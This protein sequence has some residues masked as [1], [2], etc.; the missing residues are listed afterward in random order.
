[1]VVVGCVSVGA[2]GAVS[3]LGA[4][5]GLSRVVL[6][7]LGAGR[8]CSTVVDDRVGRGLGVACAGGITGSV[9]A[10]VPGCPGAGGDVEEICG[11]VKFE[12]V[13][14]FVP[15]I[16]SGA[17]GG[18]PGALIVELTPLVWPSWTT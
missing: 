17:G 1:M 7:S 13:S 5:G 18:S 11:R 14:A 16:P 15:V 4:G 8:V 6:V 10:S 12:V 3:V 9:P 2:G